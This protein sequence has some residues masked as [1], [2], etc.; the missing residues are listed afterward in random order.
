MTNVEVLRRTGAEG[1]LWKN[2]TIKRSEI[3]RHILRHDNI[4]KLVMEGN[5]EG[6]I[7]RRRAKHNAFRVNYE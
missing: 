1:V 2:V 7:C 4:V 3:I 6:K 5:V